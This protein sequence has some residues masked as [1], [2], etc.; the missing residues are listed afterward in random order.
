M[1]L[2]ILIFILVALLPVIN[3]NSEKELRTAHKYKFIVF[4]LIFLILSIT[5]G[6][7]DIIGSDYGGHFIDF[8]ETKNIYIYYNKLYF[9]NLEPL[10]TALTS[11]MVFL[12]LTYDH[13]NLLISFILIYSLLFFASKEK[14]YLLIVLIFLSYYFLIFGM[15][16]VR[17]GLSLAFILSFIHSWRNGNIAF[18]YLFFLLAVSS[19]KFSIVTGFLLFIPPK[20]SFFYFNKYFY[21]LLFIVVLALII[22][23][24]PINELAYYFEKYSNDFS[25]G[26]I[27]RSIV[28]SSIVVIFFMKMSYFKSR[29]DFRYLYIS[30]IIILLI[31]ILSLFFSTI[32]DRLLGYFLP[33]MFIVLSNI[34]YSLKR[35]S[36][37]LIRCGITL[38]LLTHL[39]LWTNYA[40]Q[41]KYYLPYEMVNYPGSTYKQR[42]LISKKIID[43]ILRNT[44]DFM[45]KKHT[46]VKF[47]ET[48]PSKP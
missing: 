44:P 3:F 36:S 6:F 46:D 14:D 1:N 32:A 30:A 18:S 16:Y 11:L 27:Y 4:T 31:S 34:Q 42:D 38:I 21:I 29:L 7:R 19:H 33:F 47:N 12:G 22:K 35:L 37:G 9:S 8:A 28:F 15:G 5:I 45:A 17:Q 23:T 13:L 41:A 43:N 26:G 24:F 10:Y 2:Y 48:D 40:P 25:F 39:F 20:G